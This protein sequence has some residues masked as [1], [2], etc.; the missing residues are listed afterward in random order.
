[1]AANPPINAM[2]EAETAYQA[3]LAAL[4]R[5]HGNLD[6]IT[7][8]SPVDWT[9]YDEGV[10]ACSSCR[11]AAQAAESVLQAAILNTPAV[12]ELTG[13]L[14]QDTQSMNKCAAALDKTAA[15]CSTLA[16]CADTVASVLGAIL[17]Y[18]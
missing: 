7:N 14:K 8:A 11:N 16:K 5:S 17:K 9:A 15:T 6:A 10:A 3:A 1:M 4:H 18:I 2:P 13:K 12:Q